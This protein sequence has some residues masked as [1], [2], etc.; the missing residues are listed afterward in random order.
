MCYPM[1]RALKNKYIFTKQEI[2]TRIYSQHWS[3]T[4]NGERIRGCPKITAL[5]ILRLG[6]IQ[7]H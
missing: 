1:I 4:E 3:V 7:C 2:L 6:E 5:F